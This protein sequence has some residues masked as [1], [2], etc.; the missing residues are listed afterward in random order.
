MIALSKEGPPT[1]IAAT[2][3]VTMPSGATAR[4]TLS[5]HPMDWLMNCM[6]TRSPKSASKLLETKSES[7]RLYRFRDTHGARSENKLLEKSSPAR[8]AQTSVA[9]K[10]QRVTEDMLV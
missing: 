4:M 10:S 3:A 1:R 7:C 9:E 5:A 2:I 6:V 8:H